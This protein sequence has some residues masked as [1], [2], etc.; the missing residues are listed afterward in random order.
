MVLAL[1]DTN[2]QM[3]RISWGGGVAVSCLVAKS[4]PTLL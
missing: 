3:N 4:C 2:K 1:M